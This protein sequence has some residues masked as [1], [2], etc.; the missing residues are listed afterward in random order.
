VEAGG[1]L[2]EGA[3]QAETFPVSIEKQYVVIEV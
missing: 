2:V 1:A 3:L